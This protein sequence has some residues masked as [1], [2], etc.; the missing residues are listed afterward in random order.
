MA[1]IWIDGAERLGKGEIGGAMD[2]PEKPAR[3]VW[4]STESGHGDPAFKNVADYLIRKGAEPHFLYDP[5]TDRL[6]Q[7]GPLGESARALRNNG[8]VRTN[9]TGKACIQIEVLARAAT[10]FTGYWKPGRNFTKLLAAIRSW[11]IPDVFPQGTP[12]KTAAAATKR[13][14]TVWLTRAGHYGHCNVPAND[15]WDPG[16]ISTEALFKAAPTT[17]RTHKVKKGETL[18]SIG[19]AARI[20]WKTLASLNGLKSPYPIAVGQVLTLKGAAAKPT[21][22]AF[23]GAGYFRP[24]ASNA[25]VTQ[26]G[27]ALVAHGYGRFYAAGPGPTWTAVDRAAVNAFQTAQGWKGDDADGYPGPTTWRLLFP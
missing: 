11:G 7:F 6:G 17:D 16:A 20:P 24:G 1:V 25:Y 10:P 23:P 21:P 3:A 26:L 8:A 27:R 19:T 14:N 18:T 2:S 12:A 5:V 13:D 15:H 4:H 9:R 22:P